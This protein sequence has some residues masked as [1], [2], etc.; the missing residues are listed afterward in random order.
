MTSLPFIINKPL[1]IVRVG[2]LLDTDAKL[3]RSTSMQAP[4]LLLFLDHFF[5]L[6]LASYQS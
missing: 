5:Y 1:T 4:C 3:G 2:V 6:I